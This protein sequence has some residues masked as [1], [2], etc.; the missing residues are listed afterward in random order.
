[1]NLS[2]FRRPCLPQFNSH[3]RAYERLWELQRR[4]IQLL[5]L[6]ACNLGRGCWLRTLGCFG[7]I[8]GYNILFPS[9]VSRVFPNKSN[10]E[11]SEIIEFIT[12]A[13]ISD[14]II[15]FLSFYHCLR[16]PDSEIPGRGKP[17]GERDFILIV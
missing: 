17:F 13:K 10:F 15:G 11:A 1:M 14:R 5:L 7:T 6:T 3:T 9:R 4:S 2:P 8:L 12:R 16:S